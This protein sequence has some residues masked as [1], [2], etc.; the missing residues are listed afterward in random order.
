MGALPDFFVVGLYSDQPEVLA[1]HIRILEVGWN[2]AVHATSYGSV[3][4]E[5]K[6]ARMF[7]PRR[8]LSLLIAGALIVSG[9]TTSAL[10]Q[11]ASDAE[12]DQLLSTPVG[13]DAPPPIAPQL[14][15]LR[16]PLLVPSQP[17][18][19][20]AQQ[21]PT[22]VGEA[23][24]PKLHWLKSK[25]NKTANGNAQNDSAPN[26]VP[27]L[28]MPPLRIGSPVSSSNRDA[29]KEAFTIN[30]NAMKIAAPN[31]HEVTPSIY[32]GGQPTADDLTKLKA[33][34]ITTV[35]NLRN[36][37]VLVAQESRQAK[38]LG[39]RFVNIPLDVFSEP[40]PAAVK[41]FLG[42]MDSAK[43]GPVFVH[44]LHGQD[45]TGMMVAIY[46]ILRQ[47]W[48]GDQAYSEMFADGFRPG[49]SRL[50]QTV[51]QYAA[52]AGR[53]GTAPQGAALLQDMKKRLLHL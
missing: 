8:E 49:F 22:S 46:R 4:S 16:S 43:S 3:K 41:Q 50:S 17:N 44:C 34:G 32:R 48:S 27:D 20:A 51:F 1:R 31:V 42:V 37:E 52:Q 6:G 24:K 45:R 29:H 7:F 11:S 9:S 33:A 15:P 47:G 14:I 53:P 18:V 5:P 40:S 19:P 38:A 26:A 36:E 2:S 12:I 30:P 21:A 28:A 25:S 13:P 23:P 35:V 39:M 10:A